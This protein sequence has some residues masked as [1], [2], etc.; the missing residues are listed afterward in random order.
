MRESVRKTIK[1]YAAAVVVDAELN[2][3]LR[4]FTWRRV[5]DG[6]ILTVM[7]QLLRWWEVGE[8]GGGG[9]GR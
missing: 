9:G 1:C 7:L 3:S 6:I 4:E 8:F 2:W 5:T